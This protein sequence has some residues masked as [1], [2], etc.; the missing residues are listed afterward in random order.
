MSVIPKA[1]ED[2]EDLT[3]RRLSVTNSVR[4][5]QAQIESI[6]QLDEPTDNLFFATRMVALDFHKQTVP[7]KDTVQPL[8]DTGRSL[9]FSDVSSRVNGPSSSPVR[10]RVRWKS[11]DFL[12]THGAL[13][14]RSQFVW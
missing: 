5:N 14:F 11:R 4:G 1:S 13:V 7:A 10:R 3:T 2:I 12:P 8:Q 6:C 9:A